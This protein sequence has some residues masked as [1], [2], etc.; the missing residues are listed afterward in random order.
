MT[1]TKKDYDDAMQVFTIERVKERLIEDTEQL[2]KLN[3]YV[4][5]E[6]KIINDQRGTTIIKS[7]TFES[8]ELNRKVLRQNIEF[9][10]NIINF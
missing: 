9:W 10:N 1:F 4:Q 6:D 3:V 5:E 8:L 7:P 2:E